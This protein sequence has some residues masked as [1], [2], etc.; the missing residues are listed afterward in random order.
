MLPRIEFSHE[1]NLI[2]KDIRGICFDDVIDAIIQNCILDDLEHKTR[3]NQRILVVSIE[4]YDYAVP[5]VLKDEGRC[6][7]LK[8][9]YPSRAFTK[10][11]IK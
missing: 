8:T 10:H 2:L 9:V 4:K 11:Y 1:K 5:Y 6:I 7:F 3:S